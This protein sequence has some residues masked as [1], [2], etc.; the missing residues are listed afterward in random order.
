MSNEHLPHL[1][2]EGFFGTEKYN[3]APRRGAD[4]P[5]P[6]RERTAHGTSVREQLN[7]IRG[8][9]EKSRGLKTEAD[10]PA[11]ISIGKSGSFKDLFRSRRSVGRRS[12]TS[13]L[14]VKIT[15]ARPLGFF[16]DRVHSNVNV[17]GKP[18]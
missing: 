6:A 16:L 17:R 1:I 18:S 7:T 9:N 12:G 11:P 4:F 13:P 14:S 10:K 8:E 3:A 5:L 2:I 15:E